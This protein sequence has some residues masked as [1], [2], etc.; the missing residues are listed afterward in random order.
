MDRVGTRTLRRPD[1]RAGPGGGSPGPQPTD[2]PP[3]SKRL[4][5]RSV[6]RNRVRVASPNGF[7]KVGPTKS[8]VQGSRKRISLS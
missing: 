8:S 5:R 4:R 3:G 2:F 1:Q 6:I 7:G